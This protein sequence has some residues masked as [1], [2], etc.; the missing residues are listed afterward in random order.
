MRNRLGLRKRRFTNPQLL[1]RLLPLGDI[2]NEAAQAD[3]FP[4]RIIVKLAFA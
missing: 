2:L 1:F 3:R 4:V